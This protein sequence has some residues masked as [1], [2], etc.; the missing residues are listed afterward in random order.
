[1]SQLPHCFIPYLLKA[2]SFPS[3]LDTVPTSLLAPFTSCISSF[4]CYL[5]IWEFTHKKNGSICSFAKLAKLQNVCFPH[6]AF[7]W[8][9]KWCVH[10]H[11]QTALCQFCHP[12]GQHL[13]TYQVCS[14]PANVH[15]CIK[16]RSQTQ[17]AICNCIYKHV[18][19]IK[20]TR[21]KQV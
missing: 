3:I 12:T 10:C 16:L 8:Q 17:N 21:S 14:V 18:L 20:K 15:W 2:L 1:M 6:K 19:G 11:K 4:A 9:W 7:K 5:F 13:S